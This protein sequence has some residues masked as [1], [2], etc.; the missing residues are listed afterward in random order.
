[1]KKSGIILLTAM[2]IGSILLLTACT[3]ETS[4]SKAE[5]IAGALNSTYLLGKESI[6][7]VNGVF[8]KKAAP[9]SSAV[10][11]TQVWEQ[12]IIGDLN[13]DGID[14]ATVCLIN[15]P[16][17]SGTFYYIAAAIKDAN[18]K[19]YKGTNA[20]FLGD[21]IQL[22][23]LSIENNVITVTY[24][25]IQ[26]GKAMTATPSVTVSKKFKVD[27]GL[28][29]EIDKKVEGNSSTNTNTND[30]YTLSPNAYKRD[31]IT[32]EYP[33]LSGF[34]GE[35]LMGYMNQS[36]KKVVE[37]YSGS[38]YTNV[39]IDYVVTR[40]DDTVLSVLFKGTGELKNV[41]SISIMESV[42][43][44][45]GK[46]TN[47]IKYDNLIKNSDEARSF[48]K[49]KLNQA[50]EQKGIQGGLNAE[51]IRIYFTSTDVVFFYM[52]PDDNAKEF[53]ELKISK[54]E[55]EP[56]LNRDFGSRSAS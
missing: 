13:A 47:E 24:N 22:S 40:Q 11:K 41:G 45:I 4:D 21:R 38:D 3:R 34:Q 46:T 18:T 14:D 36:L 53:V 27:N 48:L 20:V 8:E 51:G 9:N 2:I 25:E 52:L 17:G 37:K 10:N 1:M 35:L 16:G 55:L 31:N 6:T 32:I 54:T 23:K 19:S 28:L 44:D 49:N 33:Q 30:S 12:P 26:A 56:Y 50:A 29:K 39:V 7:L 43:L 15:T 42:N 5:V